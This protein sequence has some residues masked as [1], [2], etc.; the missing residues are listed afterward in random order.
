MWGSDVRTVEDVLSL[1]LEL[2]LKFSQSRDIWSIE[3]H[4]CHESY[5]FVFYPRTV[6]AP[7]LP[8]LSLMHCRTWN[9]FVCR[10]GNLALK[11]LSQITEGSD[12]VW[13]AKW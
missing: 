13:I 5:I 9:R 10:L 1:K 2:A 6:I 11:L 7:P 3:W 4:I 8:G 12:A